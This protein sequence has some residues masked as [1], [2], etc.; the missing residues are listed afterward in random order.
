MQI[1]P[2]A[3][4]RCHEAGN[5][6][7]LKQKNNEELKTTTKQTLQEIQLKIIKA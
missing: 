7:Q 1:F 4:T 5:Q 2:S 3:C 6:Q